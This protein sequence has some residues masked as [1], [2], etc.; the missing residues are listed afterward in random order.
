MVS[1]VRN[2]DRVQQGQ[3]VFA[4]QHLGPQLEES[5]AGNLNHHLKACFTY[6]W[7]LMLA[8]GRNVWSP[9]VAWASSQHGG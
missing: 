8:I 9:R 2:S 1:V 6:V 3:L 5:K 7:Q 4:L